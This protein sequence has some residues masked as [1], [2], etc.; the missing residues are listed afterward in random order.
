[1]IK[2][3]HSLTAFA[4]RKGERMI[5]SMDNQI[6]KDLSR[7]I[8][9]SKV[10]KDQRSFVVEGRRLCNEAPEEWIKHLYVSES[11]LNKKKHLEELELCPYILLSDRV[12]A[13]V[14]DTKT[15]QGILAEIKMP[16]Y[17]LDKMIRKDKTLLLILEGI[18]DPGN[19]G[20]MLRAGEAAGVTGVIMDKETVDLF[21]P[22]TIRSTMGSIYRVPFL[23]ADDLPKTLTDLKKR[24]VSL[25]AAHLKGA[26]DY[27]E[28]DYTGPCGFLVGNEGNGLSDKVAKL[29]DTRVRI[30]MRGKVESL[31]AAVSATL[32]MYECNRQRRQSR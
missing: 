12:F 7:L 2:A 23:V 13:K 8:K 5:T 27:D 31:N 10:R 16:S 25:Y 19:L 6:V 20:T 32:L 29:A 4:Y 11:Y 1:M 15:P 9:K 26:K 17:T 14:S 3:V 28:P 22:K 21:N 18:Q 24:G 30:P